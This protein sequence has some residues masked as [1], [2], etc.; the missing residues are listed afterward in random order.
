[1]A[2]TSQDHLQRRRNYQQCQTEHNI[3][4]GDGGL[5]AAVFGFCDGLLSNLCLILGVY[6]AVVHGDI[7]LTS[8]LVTGFAG[9]LAGA[10]SM[11]SGEWISMTAQEEAQRKELTTERRHITDHFEMEANEFV[12]F[13][14]KHGVSEE[15]ARLVTSDINLSRQ[16]VD[17]MLH[18][19]AKFELGI[20]PD[21]SEGA[22]PIKAAV[23]SFITFAAGAVIPLVPWLLAFFLEKRHASVGMGRELCFYLTIGLSAVALFAAGAMLANYT[24]RSAY[25]SGT[26]QL[27]VGIIA[28]ILCYGVGS[29]FGVAVA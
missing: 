2:S 11:C 27:V 16:P 26:R 23:F 22:A 25:W 21:E 14:T 6:G 13:L 28:A 18:M 29:V 24:G 7:S 20:D 4:V 1:M 3:G 19:H 10:A 9:M 12:D 15:V 8:L 17:A 5:R